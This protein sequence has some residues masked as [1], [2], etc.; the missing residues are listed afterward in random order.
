MDFDV[1]ISFA[2]EERRAVV[3][4]IVERLRDLGI[5]V[6]YDDTL[7]LIG[8]NLLTTINLGLSKSRYGIIIFSPSYVLKKWTKYE[9]SQLTTNKMHQ[10][11]P[12]TH[13]LAHEDLNHYAPA[14]AGKRVISTRE[15]LERICREIVQ[16]VKGYR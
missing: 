1:F 3:E 10:I 7:L 5:R 4:P 11:L 14:I 15:G 8:D 12:V 16:V 6:W 2:S 9:L 13:N